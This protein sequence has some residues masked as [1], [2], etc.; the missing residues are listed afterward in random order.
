MPAPQAN[1]QPLPQSPLVP[2]AV[3]QTPATGLQPAA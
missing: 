1:P 3:G 2:N